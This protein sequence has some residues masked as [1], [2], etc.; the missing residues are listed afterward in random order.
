[1]QASRMWLSQPKGTA[2]LL[3]TTSWAPLWTT[4]PPSPA[5]R[6]RMQAYVAH[7]SSAPLAQCQEVC[8]RATSFTQRF[9]RN[10]LLHLVT[11]QNNNSCHPLPELNNNGSTVNPPGQL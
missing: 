5:R 4:Q 3:W 1:M 6:P 9:R 10:L 2:W 8:V 7:A 11:T